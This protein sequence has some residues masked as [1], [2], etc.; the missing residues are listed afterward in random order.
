MH[1]LKKVDAQYYPSSTDTQ[2]VASQKHYLPNGTI[3]NLFS[4]LHHNLEP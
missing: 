3:T 2:P 4:P 1:E